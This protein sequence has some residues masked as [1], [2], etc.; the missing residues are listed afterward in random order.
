MIELQ[1]FGSGAFLT[2]FVFAAVMA[3]RNLWPVNDL[4]E[5][6]RLEALRMAYATFEANPSLDVLDWASHIEAYLNRK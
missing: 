6:N 2:I 5:R 1:A 4:R 3:L